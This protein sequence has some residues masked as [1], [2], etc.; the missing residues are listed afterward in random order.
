MCKKKGINKQHPRY[1][2]YI[3]KC[4]ALANDRFQ[5]TAVAEAKF[6]NWK[7]RD[8]PAADEVRSIER[9]FNAKLRQLQAEYAFL[10]SEV[11]TR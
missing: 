6:P 10:F 5:K 8:H 7:E 2:E 9:E 1:S 3:A 11:D 4:E